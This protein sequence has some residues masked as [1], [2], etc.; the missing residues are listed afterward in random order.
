MRLQKQFEGDPTY[1]KVI[2]VGTVLL[3]QRYI[4]I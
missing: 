1:P 4:I 3:W 2:A